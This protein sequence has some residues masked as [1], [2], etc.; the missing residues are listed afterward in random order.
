MESGQGNPEL[1]IVGTS[2]SDTPSPNLNI[3]TFSTSPGD[4]AVDTSGF[5]VQTVH[6]A[7]PN[8]VLQSQSLGQGLGFDNHVASLVPNQHIH[9]LVGRQQYPAP[10]AEHDDLVANKGLFLDCLSNFHKQMGSSFRIPQMGGKELDLHLLYREVTTRSGLAQVIKDRRWKEITLPFNFPPTMTSSSFVLRKYYTNL[11]HHFE[12]VH[13]FRNRGAL[14]PPPSPLPG[15]SVMMGRMGPGAS[16]LGQPG[17]GVDEPLRRRRK[18]RAM[19]MGS[20]PSIHIGQAVT[21]SIHSRFEFGYFISVTVGNE[22]LKG[23]L[24]APTNGRPSSFSG[25][26]G[27]MLTEQGVPVK[28]RRRRRRKD[29]MPIKDPNVPKSNRSAYNYFFQEWRYK[30]KE[31]H[32][33]V[34][35]R[36]I[37][38]MIGERWNALSEEGRGPYQIKASDDKVRYDREMGSYN[39][40]KLSGYGVM[41]HHAG[42]SQPYVPAQALLP[43][44]GAEA[45]PEL[46]AE[47]EPEPE[48]EPEAMD[49]EGPEVG[50]EDPA[51]RQEHEQTGTEEALHP[52]QGGGLGPDVSQL[53]AEV[54]GHHQGGEFDG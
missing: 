27:P 4:I 1:Q 15:P 35:D 10:L 25:P 43:N 49:T 21:G 29:E 46:D 36:D 37:S 48:A 23:I 54:N 20:D 34:P 12:Q 31:S 8:A 52:A 17:L 16:P 14:V 9:G 19:E 42:P 47:A 53:V 44:E 7:S 45:E 41:S 33:E 26:P 13:Y 38:K 32:P 39:A 5:T 50:D 40:N 28:Q 2:Q 51:S 22:K 6:D 30:L 24:Y 3:T 18:R 11:L